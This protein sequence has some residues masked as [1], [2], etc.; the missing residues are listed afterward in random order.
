MWSIYNSTSL[1]AKQTTNKNEHQNG[2]SLI[3]LSLVKCHVFVKI[4]HFVLLANK[5]HFYSANVIDFIVF[6]KNLRY[7]L[8]I[9]IGLMIM[10]VTSS[11]LMDLITILNRK[12]RRLILTFNW[13]KYGYRITVAQQ[14][15]CTWKFSTVLVMIKTKHQSALHRRQRRC[16]F[17]SKMM[18]LLRGSNRVCTISNIQ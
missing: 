8:K 6:C 12:N 9:I 13:F 10:E 15:T 5:P 7:S 18:P 2:F 4:C 14:H 17:D 16:S 11:L 3:K 1:Q